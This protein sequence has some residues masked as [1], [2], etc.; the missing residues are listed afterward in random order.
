MLKPYLVNINNCI[1]KVDDPS[2]A[3]FFK[4]FDKAKYLEIFENMPC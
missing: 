4:Y 1:K 3:N 2:D